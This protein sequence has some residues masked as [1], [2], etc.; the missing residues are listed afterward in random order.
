MIRVALAASIA[1][2][3]A[4]FSHAALADESDA[5]PPASMDVVQGCVSAH[6]KARLSS[7]QEDWAAMREAVSACTSE[8][9]PLAIRSDCATWRDDL[10]RVLPTL[11]VVVE[12]GATGSPVTLEL[13]GQ[14]IEL[15]EPSAPMQTLP[16]KHRLRFLSPPF[17]PIEQ[18][19]SLAKG[20]KDHVVRVR[21]G[22]L[23]GAAA[24]ST[25]PAAVS[26]RSSRPVPWSTIALSGGALAAFATSTALLVSAL[27]KRAEARASCAPV[28]D[29]SVRSGIQ[30]RLLLSDLSGGAGL[31]FAGLAVYTYLERPIVRERV[32]LAVPGVAFDEHALRLLVQGDF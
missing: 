30:S 4:L 10:E 9:C 17:A 2:G 27:S 32:M 28:C 20:E 1:F 23:Q 18:E 8:T 24:P 22:A 11:L 21:F 25:A 15:A 13:D 3:S 19:L 12:R 14:A 5:P 6:E 16:G 29:T 26:T 31:V 7:L